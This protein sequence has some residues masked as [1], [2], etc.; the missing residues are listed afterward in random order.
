MEKD[1]R[2]RLK[3]EHSQKGLEVGQNWVSTV[4]VIKSSATCT[5]CRDED[6]D[7]EE[8]Y[9][10]KIDVTAEDQFLRITLF[11]VAKYYFGCDVKDY[12]LSTSK[13]IT[14]KLHM[15]DR[16]RQEKCHTNNPKFV[17]IKSTMTHNQH[18]GDKGN[19]IASSRNVDQQAKTTI[20]QTHYT[21]RISDNTPTKPT[22]Q[23]CVTSLS[24]THTT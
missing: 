13:K 1:E 7:Y 3:D 6:I 19:T 20:D 14:A 17:A 12:V 11:D 18:Q 23:Q 4:T 15:L 24:L 22:V 5:Y 10:L 2:F 9:R 16:T 21:C 8:R